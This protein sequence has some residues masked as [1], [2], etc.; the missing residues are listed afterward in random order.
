M[1]LN[2]LTEKEKYTL[3]LINKDRVENKKKQ[4]RWES[5]PMKDKKYTIEE[6]KMIISLFA[7]DF[8][9]SDIKAEQW[10]E[11]YIKNEKV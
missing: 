4:I 6:I 3:S 11:K 2:K 7:I 1:K 8:D 10:L 9:I 5:M